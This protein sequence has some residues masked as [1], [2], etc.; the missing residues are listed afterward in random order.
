MVAERSDLELDRLKQEFESLQPVFN[1]L[2]AEVEYALN[3]AIRN[4][5]IKTHSVISRV[6][7]L[8]SFCEKLGRKEYSIP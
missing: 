3:A 4:K 5:K 8:S 1:D 2:C 6:K 7:E